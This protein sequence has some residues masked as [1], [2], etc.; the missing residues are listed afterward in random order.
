L[1]EEE[2]PPAYNINAIMSSI[3]GM[4]AAEKDAFFDRI[5]LEQDF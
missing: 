5:I 3:K 4:K 1:E 2:E